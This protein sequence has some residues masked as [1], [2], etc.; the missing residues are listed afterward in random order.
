MGDEDDLLLGFFRTPEEGARDVKLPGVELGI[1]LGPY[2]HS[3]A[4]FKQPEQALGLVARELEAEA[5]L[6]FFL[7]LQPQAVVAHH[8]GMLGTVFG[9]RVD[10]HAEGAAADD[11]LAVHRSGIAR[12]EDDLALDVLPFVVGVARAATDV[13]HFPVPLAAV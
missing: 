2:L 7:P 12:G 9:A 11:G 8:L 13:D 6:V 10:E 3:L 1:H 4:L 5:S